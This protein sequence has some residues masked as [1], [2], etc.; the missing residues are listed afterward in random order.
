MLEP[1]FTKLAPSSCYLFVVVFG[2]LFYWMGVK[3]DGPHG[4]SPSSS[5]HSSWGPTDQMPQ[6]S[7]LNGFLQLTVQRRPPIRTGR[8][9]Q[10]DQFSFQGAEKGGTADRQAS[11]NLSL[12]PPPTRPPP[13]PT[14]P[15]AIRLPMPSAVTEHPSDLWEA[16]A[17]GGVCL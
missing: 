3:N 7:S 12:P 10:A 2:R 8:T 9:G 17:A 4:F 1:A 5:F 13:F 11:H 6:R 16:W 15:T 14:L